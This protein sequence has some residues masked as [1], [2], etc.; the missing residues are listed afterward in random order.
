MQKPVMLSGLALALALALVLQPAPCSAQAAGDFG[1]GLHQGSSIRSF[2]A[3]PTVAIWIA[4]EAM[5]QFGLDFST[6]DAENFGFMTRFAYNL[7]DRGDA[8]IM[9]G[10]LFEVADAV[11]TL[12]VFAPLAGVQYPVAN[13]FSIVADAHPFA[14][15]HRVVTEALFLEGRI[16]VLWWF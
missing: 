7:T 16:G 13:D 5:V 2:N 9:L 4:P 6:L 12:V 14:I 10:G 15:A 8:K 3:Y 1:F 11:R